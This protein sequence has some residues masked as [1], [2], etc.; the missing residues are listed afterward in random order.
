[1]DIK[2]LLYKRD[3]KMIIREE[4]KQ[5][6]NHIERLTLLAFTGHPHHEPGSSPNE[7]M[8]INRLRDAEAMTLS[9]V[10]EDDSG[11]IGHLAYSSVKIDGITTRWHALAPISVSPSRQRQ[12]IGS[13]MIEQS[14]LLL[15]ER[16]IDGLV[17]LGDPE[18]YSRFGFHHNHR[19]IV[20]GVPAKYFLAQSLININ[21]LP[22]GIVTFHKAFE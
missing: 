6:I 20:E 11:I 21:Q 13:K 8:I 2:F 15:K 19:F 17:V 7:H 12:G 4:K 5:D 9:L 1:M 14:I 16:N 10:A 22:S 3:N 18:Y